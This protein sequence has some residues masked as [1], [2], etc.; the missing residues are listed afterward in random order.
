MYLIENYVYV[1]KTELSS[2][3]IYYLIILFYDLLYRAV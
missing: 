1:G 3:V 2:L